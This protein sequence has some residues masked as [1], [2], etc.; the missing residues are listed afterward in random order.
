MGR[1]CFR[2]SQIL[3]LF[4]DAY[5]VLLSET[6]RAEQDTK[7][8]AMETRKQG[9]GAGEKVH[10]QESPFLLEALWKVGVGQTHGY[11]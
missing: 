1:N 3:R 4:S 2:I 10:R 6:R 9:Q 8:L 7:L 11:L 5:S